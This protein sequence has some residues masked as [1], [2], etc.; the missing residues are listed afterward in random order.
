MVVE[1]KMTVH[2]EASYLTHLHPKEM[3]PV[4]MTGFSISA[5]AAAD[6]TAP[7]IMMRQGLMTTRGARQRSGA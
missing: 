3:S 2:V 6:P 1:V 5:E 7:A 4:C